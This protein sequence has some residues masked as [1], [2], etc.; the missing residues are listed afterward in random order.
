M[1]DKSRDLATV[2]AFIASLVLPTAMLAGAYA[3]DRGLD[4]CYDDWS[5]GEQSAFETLL[6]ASPFVA[7]G[8]VFTA[9]AIGVT[10]TRARFP[11]AFLMGIVFFAMFGIAAL[12]L[13][14][15]G[16]GCEL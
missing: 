11:L 9:T 8:L 7:A 12:V 10:E 4:A 16:G 6:V 1:T 14:Y 5:S 2:G 3:L 15:Y 13:G